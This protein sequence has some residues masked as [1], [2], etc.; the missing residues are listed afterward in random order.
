LN[1]AADLNSNMIV[2]VNDNDMSIA[3]N[4]GGL[5]KNLALLRETK[6]KAENNFFTS[7][8]FKYVY[9]DGGNDIT[10]LIT[11]FKDAKDSNEP[12]VIHMHTKKGKGFTIAEENKETWH[13]TMP[14]T[15]SASKENEKVTTEKVENYATLMTDIIEKKYQEDSTVIAISPA[16]PGI[17][18]FTKDF[19]DRAGKQ[20]IDVGIAEEHA[21][22]FAS[23]IAANGGKP[24]LAIHSSFIQRTYDQLSQDLCLNS[25]PATIVVFNNGI[26]GSDAT[27][28]GTFDIPLISNIPNMVYLAPTNKEEYISML[29]WSIEQKEYPVAIRVPKGK[30]VTTNRKD[31]TDYSKLNTFKVVEKGSR[32]AIVALGSF[33]SLGESVKDKLKTDLNINA[34]LINP[35]Y[36]TGVD[37]NVLESLKEEHDLV[38]TLEDGILDGGFGEKITRFYSK[39]TMK[40]I[41]YGGDKE[42]TDRVPLDELYNRYHL[43]EELIVSD[44]SN[45]IK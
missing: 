27:H 10:S 37:T 2:L 28:L 21:I 18:G 29:E 14:G 15:I 23:G 1:N 30:V 7:L 25:N 44:I 4:H 22:A 45:I 8:G 11:T 41:N 6:G 19:R 32:V 35:R 20:Y 33:F 36:I 39:D 12:L 38:I 16:T 42:F 34:T 43:T 17:S 5:Y 40:V 3:E 24:I 13:W 9:I 31:I 26:T